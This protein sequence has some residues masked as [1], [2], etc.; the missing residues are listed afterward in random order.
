MGESGDVTELLTSWRNGDPEA[1][2]RLIPVVYDELRSIARRHL[3]REHGAQ[4]IQATALVH[5]TYLKLV[6]QRQAT[7]HNRAHFLAVAANI[8]RHILV[9]HARTR[10]A[11]KR[12]PYASFPVDSAEPILDSE[13]LLDLNAA[14]DL[15]EQ[16]YPGKAKLVELRYVGGLTIEETAEVLSLSSATIKR[17]WLTAKAWLARTM[18]QGQDASESLRHPQV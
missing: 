15:L 8:I 9:D 7:F 6:D 18:G 16:R 2:E 14:L 13:T 3:A 11:L 1:L 5:E 4:T 10:N 17:D 12:Q